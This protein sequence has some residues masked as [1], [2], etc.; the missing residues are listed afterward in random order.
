MIGRKKT[1]FKVYYKYAEYSTIFIY[2]ITFKLVYFKTCE[3]KK[4]IMISEIIH[5]ET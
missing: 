4:Y 3:S 2:I 5:Q 1:G